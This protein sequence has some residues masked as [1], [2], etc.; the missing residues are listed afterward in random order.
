MAVVHAL[1]PFVGGWIR[2]ALFVQSLCDAEYARAGEKPVE[3][4][5]D[6]GGSRFVD[7]QAAVVVGVFA[8]AVGRERA[9]KF[10]LPALEIERSADFIGDIVRVLVI[11]DVAERHDQAVCRARVGNAVDVLAQR[12]EPH[13]QQ[14]KRVLKVLADLDVVASQSG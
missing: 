14:R 1:L 7:Q 13:V 12:D 8:V 11:E 4:I 6:N 10:A 9:D 3:N 5:A 2:D